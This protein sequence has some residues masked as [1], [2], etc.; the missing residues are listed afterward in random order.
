[1]RQIPKTIEKLKSLIELDL[2]STRIVEL[3][4]GIQNLKN[5]R[6]LDIR[7]TKIKQLPQ[8]FHDIARVDREIKWD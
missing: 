6:I 5:L 8:Q 4:H 1:M 3:P 7:E 2:Q